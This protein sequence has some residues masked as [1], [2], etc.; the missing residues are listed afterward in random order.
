MTVECF[1]IRLERKKHI[2]PQFGARIGD[3]PLHLG[4]G[5]FKKGDSVAI[6]MQERI[7]NL[8][9]DGLREHRFRIIEAV[10]G[11]IQTY[12]VSKGSCAARLRRRSSRL[13]S[14]PFSYCPK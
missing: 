9:L 14:T 6:P 10:Q 8:V 7:V 5:A 4:S 13:A 3:L 1:G 12:E 2:L 11:G